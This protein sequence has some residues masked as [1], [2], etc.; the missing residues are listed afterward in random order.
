[1]ETQIQLGI[2]S[3]LPVVLA[4]VLA[5]ATKDAVF[6][7]LVGCGVGVVLAGFDPATGL[8]KLFQ[9]ALGNRDFIWVMMIEVA[10][11]VLI[12]F[13]LRAGVIAGFAEWASRRIRTRRG[14]SGFA[15]LIGVF[16]FF[17]DY[18][19]PL[20]GGPIARPLTDKHKV[21]REMLA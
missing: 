20:F 13:Y 1:M 14:A 5:F 19:S 9:T 6:S 7:L 3:L 17:S 10:V 4:L 8:S 11:G 16:V 21:S 2:L 12:A 15:W 18:F